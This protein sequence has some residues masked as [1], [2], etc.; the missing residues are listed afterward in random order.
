[1]KMIGEITNVSFNIVDNKVII[2]KK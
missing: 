1:M 2:D